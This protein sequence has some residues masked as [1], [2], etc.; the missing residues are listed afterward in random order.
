MAA[1][2]IARRV[3]YRRLPL[4]DV[5]ERFPYGIAVA[6]RTGA[7]ATWN[8]ALADMAGIDDSA[9]G[10]SCC[11]LFGC[12]RPGGSLEGV[13]VTEAAA[14][15]RPR[16]TELRL[17]LPG[18]GRFVSV[19]AVPLDADGSRIL[20][21]VHPAERVESHTPVGLPWLRIYTLG[22]MRVETP[23]GPLPGRWLEQRTGQLLKLLVCER[24][25]VVATDEIAEAL[26]PNP[27]AATANTVRQ[28]VHALRERLE[29]GRVRHAPSRVVIARRG[30]YTLCPE[31]V[32][33]D[34]DELEAQADRGMAALAAGRT[35]VAAEH[36]EHALALYGGDFLADD[37]YATWAFEERERLRTLVDR[38]LRLLIELHA[39]DPAAAAEYL[40]RLAQLEPFDHEIHRQLLTLWMQQG[41][42]SRAAR[43]YRAFELRLFREFGAQ[44]SFSLSELLGGGRASA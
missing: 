26:W 44:P 12:R 28:F 20:F 7:I 11:E 36:L 32:W 15:A 2:S 34:A 40:E 21:H 27:R 16:P 22:R 18:S 42:L 30:G 19:I 37:P 14:A 33:I 8:R 43:H 31:R 17:E 25:R 6:S 39:D 13:C 10:L 38:P 41:R 1:R 9:A 5:F 29:P 35:A 3:R 4:S 24:H 23:T